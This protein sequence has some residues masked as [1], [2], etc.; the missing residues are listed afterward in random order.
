[1]KKKYLPLLFVLIFSTLSIYAQNKPAYR[2]YNGK[3]KKVSYKKMIH[4]LSKADVVLFG[5]YHNNPI[6]HWLELEIAKDLADRRPLVMGA[7]M[8]ER[9][10]QEALSHYLKGEIDQEGLDTMARLWPNYKTDYAPL[11]NF[12]REKGIPFIATNIPRRYAN[13]VYRKDFAA[14]DTLSDLEKSWMA[15]LPIPFDS[16][17]PTYRK[18]LKMMGGHGSP[19][20]VK[21]QAM[22]DATMAW[23]IAHHLPEGALFLHF[24]GSFHSDYHEGI[25]WYLK[26]YRPELEVKTITTVSQDDINKLDEENLG[27][28]DFIIAVDEDMTTTY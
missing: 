12:A 16:T 22:K 18:I 14:L 1:M 5:E 2:L 3:G 7:E 23:S 15:P 17:L 10:N 21:A 13:L 27:K 28:A 19:R 8:M 4:E 11:I 25:V 6:S 26:Q 9:D 20:L 24:N